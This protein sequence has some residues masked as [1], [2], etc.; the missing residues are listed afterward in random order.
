MLWLHRMSAGCWHWGSGGWRWCASCS[1]RCSWRA[2]R[3]RCIGGSLTLG[4]LARY[5]N[6]LYNLWQSRCTHHGACNSTAGC[7]HCSRSSSNPSRNMWCKLMRD[8]G[9]QELTKQM[10]V[11]AEA[12]HDAWRNATVKCHWALTTCSWSNGTA[13]KWFPCL[14]MTKATNVYQW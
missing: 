2:G 5:R 8:W 12:W 13:L 14:L 10:L 4:M 6:R 1:C 11:R 7:G 3:M 9:S